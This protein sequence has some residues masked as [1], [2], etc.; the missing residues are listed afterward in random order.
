[1]KIC[2]FQG[3]FNPVHNAHLRIAEFV[4]NNLNFDKVIFI[5]AYIPPHKE[6]DNNLAAHR[7]N[8]LKL[9][10]ED[11]KNFFVSDIEYKR[12]GKSYT[13]FTARELFKLYGKINFLIGTDAFDKIETWYLVDELKK[14]VK[15][16]VFAR[17]DNFNISRYDYLKAKGFDFEIQTLP[18]CDISSSQIREMIKQNENISRYLPQ[19]VEEYIYKNGIYKL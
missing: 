6:C 12:K 3:T 2:V 14:L 11:Y 18:F 9:A 5:P 10:T 1:M 19:K 15:F 4:C 16:I 8:M 17:D 7:L 13:I